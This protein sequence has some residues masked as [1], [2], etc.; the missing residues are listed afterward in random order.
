MLYVRF[1][2]ECFLHLWNT[3]APC[4]G[5][6]L[7]LATP[8]QA[9]T[10]L[11]DLS[12]VLFNPVGVGIRTVNEGRPNVMRVVFSGEH[13]HYEYLQLSSPSAAAVVRGS[14]LYGQDLLR[15]ASWDGFWDPNPVPDSSS[16]HHGEVAVAQPPVMVQGSLDAQQRFPLRTVPQDHGWTLVEPRKNKIKVNDN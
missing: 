7:T 11:Y 4:D 13:G 9:A 2:R 12:I 5:R 8:R 10:E 16:S 1:R 6:A 3:N 15:G 14:D